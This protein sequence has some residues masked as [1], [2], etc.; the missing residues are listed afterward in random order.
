MNSLRHGLLSRAVVLEK[1]EDRAEYDRMLEE[2]IADYQP[3]G[4][5]QEM[6]VDRI[7]SSYWRL[8][9]VIRCESGALR[10]QLDAARRN[11]E[12]R[13][14]SLFDQALEMVDEDGDLEILIRSSRGIRY[15]TNRLKTAYDELEQQGFLSK[16]THDSCILCIGEGEESLF[17]IY[18]RYRIITAY[19][20]QPDGIPESPA[21]PTV[22]NEARQQ[23]LAAIEAELEH[24]KRLRESTL[25]REELEVERNIAIAYLPQKELA[26]HIQRYETSIERKLFNSITLLESKQRQRRE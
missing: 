10:F 9:R 20:A 13:L 21:D 5:A 17:A 22:I 11:E 24:L 8:G 15:L 14:E 25:E 4:M 6:L 18:S 12:E 26:E 1:G 3:A 2:L 23:L 19:D 7:A 16:E